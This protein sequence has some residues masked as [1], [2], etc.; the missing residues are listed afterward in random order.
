MKTGVVVVLYFPELEHL[1]KVFELLDKLTLPVAVVDNSPNALEGIPLP[2][3]STYIHFPQNSG[4][5]HAQNAGIDALSEQGVDGV[6]IFDQDSH[7]TES[8]LRRLIEDYRR[9]E[10][11]FGPVA[12]IGPK[13]ICEFSEHAVRPRLQK[14]I[15]VVGDLLDVHQIIASGM[16]VNVQAFAKIG[17]KEAPLF[18]D[19][20][21]HEWCWRARAQGYAVVQTAGVTMRHREG[22]A[23]LKLLGFT[24]KQGAPVR[25]YY[26]VRNILILS[27]RGYVPTYWKIRNI[28]V[29]PLRW[30]VNR[31]RFP[32]GKTR[33][34][35][36]WRGVKDGLKGKLGAIE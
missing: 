18:I 8:L 13:I 6:F 20:V 33:S 25:L 23:R 28:V 2:V 4:I 35:Y 22:D 19:G 15:A 17:N 24:F 27:R 9:A 32:D 7:I 1:Q 21:D 26:Q 11:L 34:H 31:W 5:A 12:V 29:L 14:P 16:L 36:F 30:Y 3:Q 10:T